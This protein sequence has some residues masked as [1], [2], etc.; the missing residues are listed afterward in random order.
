M[1]CAMFALIRGFLGF[2]EVNIGKDDALG[3]GICKSKRRFLSNP[4]RCLRFNVSIWQCVDSDTEMEEI[5]MYLH[6][7]LGLC[8]HSE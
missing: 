1:F 6:Q 8:P 5:H 3:T 4:R 2:F 7:S